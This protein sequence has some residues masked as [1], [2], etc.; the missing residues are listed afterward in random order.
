[1]T[2]VPKLGARHQWAGGVTLG[3]PTV[4]P[5]YRIRSIGGLGSLGEREDHRD[6]A[7]GRL[8][9]IPRRSVRRGKTLTYSGVI[10]A[11]TLPMLRD[12]EGALMAAFAAT[13]PQRMDILTPQDPAVPAMFFWAE[14]MAC[15]VVDQHTL[16]GIYSEWQRDYVIALRM[17]DPRVYVAAQTSVVSGGSVP[18][19]V[20][21]PQTP[22]FTIP[23][24]SGVLGAATVANP[25]RAPVDPVIDASGPFTGLTVTDL[26]R[27]VKV[28]LPGV[29]VPSGSWVRLDF[30]ARQALLEG[31]VDVTGL[32][33]FAGS[34]WWGTDVE[35]LPGAA[36]TTVRAAATNGQPV[37]V[38]V[39]F[40]PAE[41]G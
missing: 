4:R 27:N 16:D 30:Q 20:L 19:G 23:A 8:G 39:A 38:T 36:T 35:G 32:V 9:E 13:G 11:D 29:T 3:N 17:A 2:A 1:M 40:N 7:S 21:L 14:S 34:S 41:W 37:A 5:V 18:S 10:V 26:T 6:A 25:G 22:P 31:T 12:A 24:Q 28:S 33:D 15:D